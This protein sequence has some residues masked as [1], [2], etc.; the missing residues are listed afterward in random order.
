MLLEAGVTG[1]RFHKVLNAIIISGGALT[2]KA[3]GVLV[4]NFEK[5]SQRGTKLLFCGSV[6]KI[7]FTNSLSKLLL[8]SWFTLKVV[9]TCMLA[10]LFA[11]LARNCR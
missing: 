4:G 5:E 6:F 2:Q 3:R 11:F 8:D 1:F 9:V 10:R 7:F